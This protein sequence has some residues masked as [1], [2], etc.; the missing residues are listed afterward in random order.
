MWTP[1][2][3]LADVERITILEAL[4]HHRGN[5]THT[6]TALGIAIRTLCIKIKAIA[7]A[8]YEVTPPPTNSE[9]KKGKSEGQQSHAQEP[10]TQD[11]GNP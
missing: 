8:G 1:G 5:R 4:R 6:A 9:I 7:R 10:P 2:Q 3:R 11:Q